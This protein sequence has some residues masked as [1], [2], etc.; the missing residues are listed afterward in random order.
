MLYAYPIIQLPYFILKIKKRKYNNNNN[1]NNNN[2]DNDNDK[3]V[4]I[5]FRNY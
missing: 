2:D 3:M 5:S 4:L 1:N